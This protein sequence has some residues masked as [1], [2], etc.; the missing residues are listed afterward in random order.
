MTE[1]FAALRS[2]VLP[3]LDFRNRRNPRCPHCGFECSV[4]N[5]EWFHLY[6]EGEH[7]VECPMCDLGFT[8]SVHVSF[9]FNTDEQEDYD[10]E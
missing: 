2:T 10:E 3:R 8:V 5:Q 4:S 7:D 1:R 9:S 6:E